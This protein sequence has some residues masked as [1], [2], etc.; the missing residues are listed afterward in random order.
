MNTEQPKPTNEA[1]GGASDVQRVVGRDWNPARELGYPDFNERGHAIAAGP[2]NCPECGSQL[3]G[4]ALGGREKPDYG[5]C[6]GN[7]CNFKWNRD[8]D[9]KYFAVTPNNQDQPRR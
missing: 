1:A 9:R 4:T 7:G 2:F 5:Y 3:F 8:D 6:H